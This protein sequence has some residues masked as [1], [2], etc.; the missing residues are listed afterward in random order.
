[1]FKAF[2]LIFVVLWV[3][4]KLGG[5]IV[6]TFFSGLVNQSRPQQSNRQQ[7]KKQ[8]SDGNVSIEYAPK[9]KRDA[10]DKDFRGGDYVDYEE[11]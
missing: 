7:Q 4:V 6:R 9:N 10:K 3:I 11:V 1:M 2:I 8:P 5:F